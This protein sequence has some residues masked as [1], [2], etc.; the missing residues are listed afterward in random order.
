[1]TGGDL[2]PDPRSSSAG[3]AVHSP[4]WRSPLLLE[5]LG[6]IE[7]EARSADSGGPGAQPPGSGRGG[8]GEPPGRAYRS[9]APYPSRYGLPYEANGSGSRGPNSPV[10]TS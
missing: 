2:P 3:R 1:M 9:G 7:D 4:S 6:E 10:S 8:T 5:S